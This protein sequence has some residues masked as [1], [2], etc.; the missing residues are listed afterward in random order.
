MVDD[1]RGRKL[2]TG[3]RDASNR[4][5]IETPMEDANAQRLKQTRRR[6]QI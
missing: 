2:F 5:R 4:V 3:E 1:D 6:G